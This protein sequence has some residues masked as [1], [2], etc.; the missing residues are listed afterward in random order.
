MEWNKSAKQKKYIKYLCCWYLWRKYIYLLLNNVCI[1]TYWFKIN[2]NFEINF[3][4]YLF[5]HSYLIFLQREI[6]CFNEP[7]KCLS[8]LFI[9]MPVWLFVCYQSLIHDRCQILLLLYSVP[10]MHQL[11]SRWCNFILYKLGTW[12]SLFGIVFLQYIK[13]IFTEIFLWEVYII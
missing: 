5:L 9:T 13:P 8:I 3:L 12:P 10:W 7:K 11:V 2:C 4:W 1:R 6:S